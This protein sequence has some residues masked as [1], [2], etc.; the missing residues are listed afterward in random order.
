MYV[1]CILALMLVASLSSCASSQGRA[2]F[3]PRLAVPRVEPVDMSNLT[4][5]QRVMLENRGTLNIYKTLANHVEL[6]NRWSPL[7][8]FILNGSSI[9]PRHREMAM[10]RIGWLCQSGYEWSQHARI[11]K[12]SAGMKEAEIRAI[13]M[14]PQAA[15]WSDLDRA[16][17]R[18][19]DELR[20]EAM[21]SDSTWAALKRGYSEEQIMEL[22][23]TSAQ[24]QLVSM[25]LNSLGV[26]LEP[27]AV[28]FMPKDLPMPK[29]AQRPQAA[30]LTTP[31]LP[32]LPAEQ[33]SPEQ[34][35]LLS[36]RATESNMPQLFATTVRKPQIH[37]PFAA[38]ISH[39]TGGTTLPPRVSE[40]LIL[41]TAWMWNAEYQYAQHL[42]WATRVGLTQQEVARIPLGPNAE[43]WRESDRAILRA[44]DELRSEAF[45]SDATWAELGRSLDIKQRIELI[46]T[47]G[48]YAMAALAS[49]SFGTPLEP[50]VAGFPAK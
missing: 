6:Y 37:E 49:N 22:L 27:T 46:Y 21:I 41:R 40:M 19:A 29:V 20:Y 34:T 7:G 30:R 33:W 38:F 16:V 31:R 3:S 11:A 28:D 39:L 36:E 13:A 2:S 47:V 4:E 42:P 17:L 14:G 43:G 45:I 50:N 10:L 5:P 44:V 23:F 15:S 24:Y 8:R 26:Q 9:Q 32:P 12:A 25:A 35:T 1:R 48:G 18:M